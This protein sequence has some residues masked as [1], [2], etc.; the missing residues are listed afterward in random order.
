M[1]D[2]RKETLQTARDQRSLEKRR[3]VEEAIAK[4]Q[5]RKD[6]VT[7]KAVASMA[8]VSRQYLYNNFK[9]AIQTQREEDRSATNL[10]EGVSVPSRTPDEARHVEALLRNKLDRLKKELGEVRSENAR[11]KNA[12]EKE[13]GNAEHFRQLWISSRN[14]RTDP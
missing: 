13:R 2:G 11:L 3:A 9:D 5:A 6:T 14:G 10:I 12:L 1:T 7:F 4:L 8:G